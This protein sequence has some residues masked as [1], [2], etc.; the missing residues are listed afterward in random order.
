MFVL[1][2]IPLGI[3]VGLLAGGRAGRLAELH[4]RWPWLAVLGLVAQVGLFV[5]P[6]GSSLGGWTPAAYVL[7]NVAVLAM[8]L[9]NLPIAGMPVVAVG[10][11]SNLA[12][13]LANGGSMPADPGAL[14]IAGIEPGGVTNS[15]TLVDPALRLLTDI[16]AIPKNVPLANVYSVGDV[17][18]GV[19][20]A[21]V[22]ALAMRGRP[23]VPGETPA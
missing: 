22:I 17:L 11:A 18:I 1:Y 5:G 16:F 8:V 14:A 15:V 20:V 13:I 6:L 9:R 12:A 4:L 21:T 3:A 2:A 19:G 23:G 10:A 7:S